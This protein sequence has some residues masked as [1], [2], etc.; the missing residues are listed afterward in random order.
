MTSPQHDKNHSPLPKG[1][2][3]F[4]MCLDS[5]EY[6]KD[7]QTMLAVDLNGHLFESHSPQLPLA[8]LANNLETSME[9]L[10]DSQGYNVPGYH[11][12]L[13]EGDWICLQQQGRKMR[14]PSGKVCYQMLPTFGLVGSW[15]WRGA[16]KPYCVAIVWK[17]PLQQVLYFIEDKHIPHL[18]TNRPT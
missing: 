16:L 9:F 17:N 10:L 1:F 6:C 3:N 8:E 5:E 18:L 2:L 7:I 15:R 14:A 4:H 13:K 12:G 11:R